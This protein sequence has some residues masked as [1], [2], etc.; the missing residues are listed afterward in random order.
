MRP[1][2]LAALCFLLLF[3][4]APAQEPSAEELQQQIER[5]LR[6]F[7]SPARQLEELSMQLAAF[8]APWEGNG[9]VASLRMAMRLIGADA[10]GLSEEQKDRLPLTA[11][12]DGI[13]GKPYQDFYD[14][15]SPE[16]AKLNEE[17]RALLVLGGPF[18][19]RATK[20][21]KDAILEVETKVEL[22]REKTFQTTI[23]ETLTP[24]QMREVRKLEMQLMAEVGMPFPTMFEILDLTDEQKKEMDSIVDEM[25]PEYE[26]L[27]K[28]FLM[29]ESEE[30]YSK[31]RSELKGKTFASLEE[32]HKSLG[33]IKSRFSMASA[34]SNKR[35]MDFMDR[36]TKLGTLLQDRMMNVLTDEQL[37]KM[38]EIMDETPVVIKKFLDRIKAM[39][40]FQQKLP[41][42]TPG[43]DSWRPGMPLPE[44][45]KEERKR[46][47]R[48]FPR[49]E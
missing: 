27:V 14:N 43:P 23:E 48:G 31:Y 22:L 7:Q 10:L 37:D 20:E 13:K 32:L 46:T 5:Q 4:I 12:G 3:A 6:L 21:Q 16:L 36:G 26:R 47:G 40:E 42:Y 9:T 49:S 38:Q 2:L 24:E 18:L 34:E 30:K 41:V 17:S 45:F 33:E 25:K 15:P 35:G 11:D 19:E 44:Q 39:R 8:R 1:S 28:E 29:L